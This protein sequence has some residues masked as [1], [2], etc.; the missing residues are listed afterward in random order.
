MR[1]SVKKAVTGFVLLMQH[2]ILVI[3]FLFSLLSFLFALHFSLTPS[4]SHSCTRSLAVSTAESPN[5]FTHHNLHTHS[6]S[7]WSRLSLTCWLTMTTSPPFK[8]PPSLPLPLFTPTP[9]PSLSVM[10]LSPS[11]PS[12]SLLHRRQACS[13]ALARATTPPYTRLLV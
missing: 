4:L 3:S 7:A 9:P 10:N 2:S 12:P 1:E 13:L 8:T 11:S 6:L 5:A